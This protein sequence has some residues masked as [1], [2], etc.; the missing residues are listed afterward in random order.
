MMV[1]GY[2]GVKGPKDDPSIAGSAISYLALNSAL[3]VFVIKDPRRREAKSDNLFRYAVCYD[4]SP[5][6]QKALEL[7]V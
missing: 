3:P 5:Q 6:A 2:N 1:T 7:V 4:G